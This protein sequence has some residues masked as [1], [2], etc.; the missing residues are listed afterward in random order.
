MKR[1]L[2]FAGMTYYPGGGWTDFKGDFDDEGAA[3]EF[4]RGHVNAKA[5]HPNEPWAQVVD[6]VPINAEIRI[7][8]LPEVGPTK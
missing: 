1:Y 3:I 5:G 6:T 2:V 7:L 4:A 8:E